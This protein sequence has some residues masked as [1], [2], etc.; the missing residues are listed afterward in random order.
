MTEIS[1]N[2]SREILSNL[3]NEFFNEQWQLYQKVLNENYMGHTEIYDALHD[4]LVNNYN[5]A[6]NIL[7]LGCGDASFSSQV[8]LDTQVYSYCGIDLSEPALE[9]ARVNME[10]VPGEKTFIQGNLFDFVLIE[11]QNLKDNFDV[12]LASFSLHHLSL[13]QKECLISQLPNLLKANG[14]F[15]L[16]DIVRLPG[17]DREAYIKRYLKNVRQYWSLLTPQEFLKVEEHISSSDFPETQETLY[18]LAQ[19]TKFSQ[20]DCLYIDPLDTTQLLCFYK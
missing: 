20:V 11:G 4:F 17:E 18:S 1:L 10:K 8:L 5:K 3:S 19:K 7:D 13:E 6:F 9:I 14:V 12:I 15:L 16:I 2:E